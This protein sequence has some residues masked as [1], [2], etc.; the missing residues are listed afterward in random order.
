MKKAIQ[1]LEL[2]VILA[3]K[4]LEVLNIHSK[5]AKNTTNLNGRIHEELSTTFF[6]SLV[7]KSEASLKVSACSLWQVFR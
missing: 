3:D 2:N 4:I 5:E 1:K 6:P 7:K